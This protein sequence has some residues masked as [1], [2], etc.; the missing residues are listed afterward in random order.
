MVN[1]LKLA[2]VFPAKGILSGV[3]EMINSK[4]LIGVGKKNGLKVFKGNVFGKT[5]YATVNKE[6]ELVKLVQKKPLRKSS[7]SPFTYSS[8]EPYTTWH[9][10]N[11]SGLIK[12][13]S[14]GFHVQAK[15]YKSG[16]SSDMHVDS[17][18]GSITYNYPDGKGV[19]FS[20]VKSEDKVFVGLSNEHINVRLLGYYPEDYVQHTFINQNG[21]YISENLM[22]V[23]NFDVDKSLKEVTGLFSRYRKT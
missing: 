5:T 3:E 11:S 6:N 12:R 2:K 23:F 9:D 10:L 7:S 15:D 22:D 8:D 19:Q 17:G 20:H 1:L 16:I 21:K 13:N 4:N 18:Y 14:S